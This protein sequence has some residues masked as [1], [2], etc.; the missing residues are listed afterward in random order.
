M[1]QLTGEPELSAAGRRPDLSSDFN[2]SIRPFEN[3]TARSVEVAFAALNCLGSGR[4]SNCYC[5]CLK[6]GVDQPVTVAVF[7]MSNNTPDQNAINTVIAGE[8]ET[9]EE[10]APPVIFAPDA[11]TAN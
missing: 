6:L 5:D 11:G 10:R 9:D 4:L 3:L 2:S 8:S 7:R 1:R